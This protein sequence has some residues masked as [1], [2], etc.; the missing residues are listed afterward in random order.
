MLRQCEFNGRK[1]I[2]HFKLL[3]AAIEENNVDRNTD[4]NLKKNDRKF[5]NVYEHSDSE[6]E[7]ETSESR[8]KNDERSQ[9][10][11]IKGEHRV[12][13]QVDLNRDLRNKN[14]KNSFE[15]E[16]GCS[17]KK[18]E[19]PFLSRK[20]KHCKRSHHNETMPLSKNKKLRKNSVQNK[21]ALDNDE[22]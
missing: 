1:D 9:Y 19:N 3:Q 14:K 20:M 13:K 2:L 5:C 21:N 11:S 8:E 12:R 7:Y 18:Y 6:N 10:Q 15:K 17:Q 16:F 4:L 22:I